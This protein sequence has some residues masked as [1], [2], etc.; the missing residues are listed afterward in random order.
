MS[1]II[2]S[3]IVCK[4]DNVD[5]CG[6][7]VDALA[8]AGVEL[9]SMTAIA[10][11]GTPLDALPDAVSEG[12]ATLESDAVPGLQRGIAYG[13]ATGLL[14]GLGATVFAPLGVVVGGAGVA[15]VSVTGAS[16]GAFVSALIGT[17][18]SN[19]E[20]REFEESLSRGEVLLVVPKST[21]NRQLLDELIADSFTD[22]EIQGDT[23]GAPPAV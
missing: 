3:Y 11:E 18:V 5:R 20:I 10:S 7:L 17:S 12:N 14:A 4:L 15:L 1:A 6:A 21:S 19:S 9:E 13:G 22:A 2:P 23:S 16:F 8:A